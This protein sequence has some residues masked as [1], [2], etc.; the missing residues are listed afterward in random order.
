MDA[1][2]SLIS[3][4]SSAIRLTQGKQRNKKMCSYHNKEQSVTRTSDWNMN[5]CRTHFR[6]NL[7]FFHTSNLQDLLT[8]FNK[9]S[10]EMKRHKTKPVFIYQQLRRRKR[11]RRLDIKV[12]S[13]RSWKQQQPNQWYRL[14]NYSM[15]R[16]P[17][18]PPNYC[19]SLTG[20][21]EAQF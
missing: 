20:R 3:R 14:D 1:G 11:W 15:I 19:R 10:R 12:V 7:I 21:L 5:I 18:K 4:G 16:R 2:K 13:W 9:I 17:A 8:S 6:L